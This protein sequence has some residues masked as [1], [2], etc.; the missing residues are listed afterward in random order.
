MYVCVCVRACHGAGVSLCCPKMQAKGNFSG[1]THNP[2][3]HST[4]RTVF[5]CQAWGRSPGPGWDGSPSRGRS[6]GS[7]P[8]ISSTGLR[9][10]QHSGPPA[11]AWPLTGRRAAEGKR[12]GPWSN[13]Q[14]TK[15]KELEQGPGAG[16]SQQPRRRGKR[17]GS[18][19]GALTAGTKAS[20]SPSHPLHTAAPVG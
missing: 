20:V 11:P 3:P 9:P 13:Q 7:S 1:H 17:L 8:P 12:P 15:H 6:E 19:P 14:I 5:L 16:A 4:A 2:A 10:R 18:Q